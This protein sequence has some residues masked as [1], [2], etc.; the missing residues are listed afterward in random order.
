MYQGSFTGTLKTEYS[1][2]SRKHPS[3]RWGFM[4]KYKRP[5]KDTFQRPVRHR[6][7]VP[8]QGGSARSEKSV[9]KGIY[10]DEKNGFNAYF[11]CVSSNIFCKSDCKRVKTVKDS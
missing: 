3:L 10:P 5:G 1:K 11:C 7:K 8:A 4:A 9:N 6:K 2:Q